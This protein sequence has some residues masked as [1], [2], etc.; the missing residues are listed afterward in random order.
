LPL[1]AEV[2][3]SLPCRS[4]AVAAD[5][6]GATRSGTRIIN[7]GTGVTRWRSTRQRDKVECLRERGDDKDPNRSKEQ[8]LGSRKCSPRIT[9]ASAIDQPMTRFHAMPTMGIGCSSSDSR[10]WLVVEKKSRIMGL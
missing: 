2:R 10:S 3:F 9:G 4:S 5:R 7:D 6:H 8:R 1:T